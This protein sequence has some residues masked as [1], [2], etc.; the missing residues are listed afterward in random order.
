ML[1]YAAVAAGGL[2]LAPTLAACSSS[3]ATPSG[4]TIGKD[5]KANLVVT[6]W[7]IPA[8]LITYKKFAAEYK[9]TH[10]GV[11][12]TVQTTLNGD[13]NQYLSN[14][15][16]GG[17]APDIIRNTWQQIGRWARNGGFIPLNSYLSPDYGKAFGETFWEAATLNG[18][19]HGIPQ[20]TDTFGTYYRPDVM[21]QIGAK[22]PGS[23]DAAWTWDEFLSLAREVKKAIGKA[24]VSYGFE[25][26]NTAHRWLPFLY[27]H[28][29]KLMEDDGKTPAINN[30]AGVEAITWFHRL[31]AEGLIPKSNTI[32]GS[33]TA[34]V[35]NTFITGEIGLMIWGDWIMGDISKGLSQDKWNITYMPRDKTAASDLGG[36]LLSV[37]KTSKNPAI[38]ADFIQF[39]SNEANMKYFCE[40]DLFLPVRTSLMTTPLDF[41]AQK[42][43]MTLFSQQA[44]TVPAAMAKVE[45]LSNFAA[46]NQALA[47]QLDLCFTG[48]QSPKQ[49]ASNISDGIKNAVA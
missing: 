10:V 46:I 47:D 43:Q 19:I 31:Y 39:V 30:A 26:V 25:G 3:A 45:T 6:N 22:V 36:N 35:E 38:A 42:E 24:A 18:Q 17:N 2:A 21:K 15:L 14:Q 1:R 40:H 20:H 41:A 23:F 29:G 8:D 34:S 33:A 4:A 49:T 48:Q 13:F 11:N 28:G 16:A 27:M 5:A 7:N 44:T 12:I 9:K 32:K 37:S